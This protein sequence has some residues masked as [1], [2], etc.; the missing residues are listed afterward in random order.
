MWF[1]DTFN[2]DKITEYI[3][4]NKNILKE[5]LKALNVNNEIGKFFDSAYGDYTNFL[6]ECSK[7]INKYSE[8]I[9]SENFES[10]KKYID[11]F[12]DKVTLQQKKIMLVILLIRIYTVQ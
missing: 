12:I 2:S 4:D 10:A 7:Y 5:R 6:N 11:E 8:L 1:D 3:D 9:K